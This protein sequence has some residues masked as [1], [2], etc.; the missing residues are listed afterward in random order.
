MLRTA[1]LFAFL[2]L[3]MLPVIVGCDDDDPARPLPELETAWPHLDGTSWQYAMEVRGWDT[4]PFF[5]DTEAFPSLEE[6]YADLRQD[7]AVEPDDAR[8][9]LYGM[10]FSGTVI[11]NSGVEAQNL[12]ES[13]EPLDG[14]PPTAAPVF[15][16][17]LPGLL[18]AM[19]P[20]LAAQLGAA[21]D[22]VEFPPR[23]NF[24]GGYA[25]A[26][27]DSGFYGYGDLNTLHS[28]I[29]LQDGLRPG[30]EFSLQL[31]PSLMDDV[32][33]HGRVWSVRTREV[34]GRRYQDVVECLYAIDLGQS[35][36]TDENGE[37]V[38]V[39]NSMLYGLLY[40]APGVGPVSLIERSVVTT[41]TVY[42]PAGVRVAGEI[43]CILEDFS[44]PD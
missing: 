41:R 32:W 22:K 15:A 25:F 28:W 36:A 18:A 1:R 37:P 4:P 34:G 8:S 35:T 42:N 40:Y 43:R 13:S 26:F 3:I 31:A 10:A 29:Y 2:A 39:F 38:G 14:L 7:V 19:R 21:S 17:R 11:T 30:T 33:L 12:V 5:G 6:M 27:E 23:P 9:Y 44:Q 20:E 24:L 16:R